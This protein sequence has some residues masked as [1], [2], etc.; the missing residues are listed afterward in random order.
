MKYTRSRDIE[1]NGIKPLPTEINVMSYDTHA[2][3]ME[4]LSVLCRLHGHMTAFDLLM[5]AELESE[6]DSDITS[7]MEAFKA[8]IHP[9]MP[10]SHYTSSDKR[11]KSARTDQPIIPID[12]EKL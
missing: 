3:E 11:I 12:P 5:G 6:K 8:Y 7:V 9:R 10:L 4:L 2:A 1:W